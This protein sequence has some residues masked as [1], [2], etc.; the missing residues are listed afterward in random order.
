MVFS[1]EGRIFNLSVLHDLLKDEFEEGFKYLTQE[2]NSLQVHHNLQTQEL[3]DQATIIIS[4]HLDNYSSSFDYIFNATKVNQQESINFGQILLH[5]WMR[6][7][8]LEGMSIKQSLWVFSRF[9]DFSIQC[10]FGS[11]KVDI[12]KMFQSGAIPTVYF[13]LLQVEPD[14]MTEDYHWVTQ[15]RMDWVLN[16]IKE[17]LGEDM[18]NYI[19]NLN[20]D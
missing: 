18:A 8:T 5:D 16:K 10:D 9:E 11:R 12:F 1:I 17:F 19:E 14:P 20:H 6:K 3:I 4:N 2:G 13:C 7:N 15:E